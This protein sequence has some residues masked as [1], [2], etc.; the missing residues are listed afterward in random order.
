[1]FTSAVI[2]ALMEVILLLKNNASSSHSDAENCKGVMLSSWSIAEN[3]VQELP[4]FS[5]I[6]LEK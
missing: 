4:L 2:L 3:N 6:I 5:V 1:M